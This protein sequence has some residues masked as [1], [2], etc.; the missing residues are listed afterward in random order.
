MILWLTAC[1]PEPPL[2]YPEIVNDILARVDADLSGYVEAEE[3]ARVALPGARLRE[4]DKNDDGRLS[5]AEVE[6]SLIEDSVAAMLEEQARN[7]L[8]PPAR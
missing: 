6:A 5:P 7:R 8:G 1:H 2:R 4:Y 3:F